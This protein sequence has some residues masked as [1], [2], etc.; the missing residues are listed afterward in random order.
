MLSRYYPDIWVSAVESRCIA[1]KLLERAVDIAIK[2]FPIL[3]LSI[4]SG[5]ETIISTHRE[6]WKH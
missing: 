1:A 2:K 3:T 5:E 6:P 4:I